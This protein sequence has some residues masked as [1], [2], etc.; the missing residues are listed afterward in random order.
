MEDEL[1]VAVGLGLAF[2]DEVGGG[3]VGDARGEVWGHRAIEFI[4]GV[5][6]VHDGGHAVETVGD[7]LAGAAAV[8]EPIGDVLAGD[9]QR[10]AVFHETDAVDI[11]HLGA[12]H[13]LIDPAHDVAEDALAIV[14]EFL[15]DLGG[16]KRAAAVQRHG[17]D[18]VAGGRGA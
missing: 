13:A 9:T 2:E 18:E 10:R 1:G 8:L 14:V 5:L 7:L 11:G 3:L 17:H 15:A 4:A 6:A 12:A 16:G